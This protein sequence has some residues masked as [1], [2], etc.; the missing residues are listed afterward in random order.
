MKSIAQRHILQL[1]VP[2]TLMSLA[3]YA[4]RLP[5]DLAVGYIVGSAGTFITMVQAISH[6]ELLGTKS[7]L[8]PKRS[9]LKRPHV[10][11]RGKQ[12]QREETHIDI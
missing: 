9:R 12:H 11:K 2:I 4:L 5:P 1:I 3:C 8:P 6:H 10:L 7:G